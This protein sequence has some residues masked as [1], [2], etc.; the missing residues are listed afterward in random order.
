MRGGGPGRRGEKGESITC[1]LVRTTFNKRLTKSLTGICSSGFTFSCSCNSLLFSYF[2]LFFFKAF[3]K[4][5]VN[6]SFKVHVRAQ[7]YANEVQG[8]SNLLVQ[9]IYKGTEGVL[10]V[11]TLTAPS[12]CDKYDPSHR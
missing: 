12:L 6:V 8:Y 3:F 11:L 10:I 1:L 7:Q 9:G 4:L 5:H 2:F